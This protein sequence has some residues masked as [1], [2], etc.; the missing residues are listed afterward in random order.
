MADAPL[1]WRANRNGRPGRLESGPRPAYALLF[2][3]SNAPLRCYGPAAI[4]FATGLLGI[5]QNLCSGDL[6]MGE[7]RS[8]SLTRLHNPW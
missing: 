5:S 8:G 2:Q 6:L 1:G 3:E 7:A 4:P